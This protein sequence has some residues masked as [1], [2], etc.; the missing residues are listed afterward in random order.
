MPELATLEIGEI[1][2]RGK[3]R[4]ERLFALLGDETSK[5]SPA[6]QQLAV[7]HQALLAAMRASDRTA[8]DDALAACIACAFPGTDRLYRSIGEERRVAPSS[9]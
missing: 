3:A 1:L 9:A 8:F 2:L 6:F 4:P 7:R 5:A